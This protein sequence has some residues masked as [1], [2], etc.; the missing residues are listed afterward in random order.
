MQVGTVNGARAHSVQASV[1]CLISSWTQAWEAQT[2]LVF[3]GKANG[4]VLNTEFINA[5]L[6]SVRVLCVW[7]QL[8][9]E[10][11]QLWL[12]GINP[13][14][15]AIVFF[16]W[17][18]GKCAKLLQAE[19][20]SVTPIVPLYLCLL[21]KLFQHW[22]IFHVSSR[23]GNGWLS[24]CI[25]CVCLCGA[26]HCVEMTGACLFFLIWKQTTSLLSARNH[27]A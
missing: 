3:P 9:F 11:E 27:P 25:T 5:F 19:I 21:L 7:P 26:C 6:N 1:L 4:Y 10:P 14:T 24:A 8:K 12:V 16:G 13:T 18:F 20:H 15:W 22:A 17:A 23:S 2:T